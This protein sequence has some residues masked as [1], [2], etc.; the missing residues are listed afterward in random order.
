MAEGSASGGLLARSE[1]GAAPGRDRGG[2]AALCSLGIGLLDMGHI[3]IVSFQDARAAS[4]GATVHLFYIYNI[5]LERMVRLVQIAQF[6]QLI[7]LKGGRL[8]YC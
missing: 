7:P 4:F 1:S 3:P 8:G 5:G 6:L 2:W